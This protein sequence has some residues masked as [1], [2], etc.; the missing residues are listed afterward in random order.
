VRA[1]AAPKKNALH[2]KDVQ[3]IADDTMCSDQNGYA[4]QKV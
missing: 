1:C 4:Q 3:G 2:I